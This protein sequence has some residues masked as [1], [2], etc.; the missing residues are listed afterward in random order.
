MTCAKVHCMDACKAVVLKLGVKVSTAELGCSS[1]VRAASISVSGCFC[2]FITVS[3]TDA[4]AQVKAEYLVGRNALTR[5]N[6]VLTFIGGLQPEPG[7]ALMGD[8]G[9]NQQSAHLS[10]TAAIPDFPAKYHVGL[11]TE[12][13]S[14]H[15]QMHLPPTGGTWRPTARSRASSTPG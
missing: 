2:S 10:V 11:Y 14:V 4:N 13:A 6:C 3:A 7:A 8:S 5:V 12:H 9:K 15:G 1:N